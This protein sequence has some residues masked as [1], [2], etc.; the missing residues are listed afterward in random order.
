[1]ALLM[2]TPSTQMLV[3]K[4]HSLLKGTRVFGECCL[5]GGIVKLGTFN[6]RSRG[7][8]HGLV[9]TCEMAQEQARRG[10]Q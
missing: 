7:G 8:A 4:Y 9:G 6:F 1:M 3:S 5:P 10:S 2:G